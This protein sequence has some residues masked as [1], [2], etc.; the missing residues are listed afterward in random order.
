MGRPKAQPRHALVHPHQTFKA[1]TAFTVLVAL[2]LAMASVVIPGQTASATGGSGGS[3]PQ[4]T[5]EFEWVK[6]G[7]EY[8]WKTVYKEAKQLKGWF[9][10]LPN[11]WKQGDPN[12]WY[13]LPSEKQP[14]RSD[15]VAPTGTVPLS[16]YGG[17]RNVTTDYKYKTSYTEFF[18][19]ETGFSAGPPP[20]GKDWGNPVAQ[21]TV[22]VDGP[23]WAATS[24]GN[25]WEKTSTPPR[26]VNCPPPFDWNWQYAAPTCEGLTVVYPSNIPAGSNHKDVNIRVKDLTTG[27]VK[28]FNFHNSDFDTNG[29]TIVY[30]VRQH[31]DWP[32]WTWYEFQWTQVHG[33]NYHWEGSVICGTPPITKDSLASV[34]VSAQATCTAPSQVTFNTLNATWDADPATE[35]GTHTRTA[36]ATDG[37]LFADGTNK[38]TVTYIIEPVKP[39][40]STDPKGECYVPPTPLV[41]EFT[42]PTVNDVCGTEDDGVTL[43]ESEDGTFKVTSV[44]PLDDGRIRH[45]VV[46]TPNDGFTVPAPVEGDEYEVVDGK[47]V[48]KL[49]TTDEPCPPVEV[50]SNGQYTVQ[51]GC[52]PTEYDMVGGGYVTFTFTN[53]VDV[54]EGEVAK[55][56]EFTYTDENGATQTVTVPANQVVVR[57]ITFLED[58]GDHVVTVGLKGQ[59]QEKVTVKTDCSPNPVLFT[60]ENPTF[61]DQCTLANDGA[62]VPGTLVSSTSSTDN[63]T[64]NIYRYEEYTAKTGSYYVSYEQVDGKLSVEIWFVPNDP[65][66]VPTAPGKDD[67]YTIEYGMAVWRHAFTNEACPTSTP[68]PTPTPEKPI[69]PVKSTTPVKTVATPPKGPQLAHT[70]VDPLPL[71]GGVGLLVLL[72]GGLVL[73]SRRRSSGPVDNSEL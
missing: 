34:E 24:P 37:H 61:V 3:N 32:G 41:A 26:E 58:S 68:T 59:E 25:G 16:V 62:N 67:T 27:T 66:A 33:T 21:Q 48:W 54:K 1:T 69:T 31:A 4:C 28:T 8:R 50:P 17:P 5:T 57:T 51:M 43:G 42:A 6:K 49:Y 14:P 7:T 13:D 36:T 45:R 72:G 47:A 71:V 46:F 23:K 65:Y 30:D 15:Q 12:T 20:A 70:G 19:S 22:V 9:V 55:D 63:L 11:T 40:Q 10:E 18:P 44:T 60:P 64:G 52:V 39:G 38:A 73:L 56:A 2:L 35:P 53:P 29:K